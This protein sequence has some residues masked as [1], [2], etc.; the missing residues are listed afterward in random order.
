MKDLWPS[1]AVALVWRAGPC[2]SQASALAPLLGEGVALR[3]ATYSATEGW[4]NVPL[5]EGVGG[6]LHPG[7]H[8]FEFAEPSTKIDRQDLMPLDALEPGKDYEVFLT[9]AMGLFR[10]RIYDVVRCTGRFRLTPVVE[11]LHKVGSPIRVGLHQA[12][13]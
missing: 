12:L 5:G 11:F 4:F 6:P 7:A 13:A 8:I 10:Y 1:L 9:T 3:D 2:G